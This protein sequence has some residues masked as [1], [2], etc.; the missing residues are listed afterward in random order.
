[1]VMINELPFNHIILFFIFFLGNIVPKMHSYINFTNPYGISLSNEKL[2]VIHK[3][4]IWICDKNLS[5]IIKNLTEFTEELSD[6]SLLTISYAYEYEYLLAIINYTLYIINNN[7]DLIEENFMGYI[8]INI[9]NDIYFSI[10]PINFDEMFY[11]YLISY[12]K[13]QDV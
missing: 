7:W 8:N 2:L 1:M 3:F 4:G 10:I 5:L 11:Y 9:G 13:D 12:F 6:E